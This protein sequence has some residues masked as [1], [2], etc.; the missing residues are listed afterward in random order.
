MRLWVIVMLCCDPIIAIE[1]EAS[2]IRLVPGYARIVTLRAPHNDENDASIHAR[3]TLAAAHTACQ[4]TTGAI[5]IRSSSV[6]TEKYGGDSAMTHTC[7]SLI[8]PIFPR[9]C[10]MVK[11]YPIHCLFNL[12]HHSR[13]IS[14]MSR[15][16]LLHRQN[17]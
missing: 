8:S 3:L 12:F 10:M 16:S 11:T 1:R 2:V 4:L 17:R 14:P 13:H 5:H 7:L 6:I 15:I 9:I